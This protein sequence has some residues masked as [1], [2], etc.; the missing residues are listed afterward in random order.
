[1]SRQNLP[2]LEIELELKK[3]LKLKNKKD[4]FKA[5]FNLKISVLKI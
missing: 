3:D 2:E 5:Y 1:M 4:V